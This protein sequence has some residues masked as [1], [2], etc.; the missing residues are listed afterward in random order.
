[1]RYHSQT[2]S[3]SNRVANPDQPLNGKSHRPLRFIDLFAGLGGFHLA[4][5]A[6]EHRCVFACEVDDELA[7]VYQRNFAI[8]PSGDIRTISPRSI[9]SHDVLC[10][11]LPCQPFSKAG[12]QRGLQCPVSGD[13]VDY[14]VRILETHRPKYFIIENV[15]NIMKHEF[16]RTWNTIKSRLTATGYS[17]AQNTLSPHG[18]GVP[19]LRPRTFVV[20]ST[21]GLNRFSWP[22]SSHDTKELS[23]MQVLDEDSTTARPLPQRFIEYLEAWQRFL[24]S[25]PPD[26]DLPSFPIWAMEFGATYPYESESPYGIGYSRLGSYKGSFGIP[27]TGLSVSQ[28]LEHLP[29]YVR[30]P[31]SRFPRWKINFIRQNRQLYQRHQAWIKDWL[32]SISDVASSY[33]KFEWNCKG[34]KR[35]IWDHVIQF[36]ASGIRV[37]R[38]TM[39]PSLVAMTTSQV[40]IIGWERRYMTIREC[41]RLQ[42]MDSLAE[43]P[44]SASAAFKALGNAVN[45]NVVT[46]IARSLLDSSSQT[47]RASTANSPCRAGYPP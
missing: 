38:S 4:L 43:F 15:P 16:G 44:H 9:P 18:F 35:N 36:R 23:I 39:A 2:S 37:K 25:Y 21:D 27:L 13:L 41:G 47:L 30:A 11:G 34:E 20:G 3:I 17:V 45:V 33:Q 42:S 6:L 32:P 1:M 5:A 40:P 7:R 19:H 12:N 28:V 31:V 29:S 46:E 10:A 14:V 22:E 8:H 26:E 24:D